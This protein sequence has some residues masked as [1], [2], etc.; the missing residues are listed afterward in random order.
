MRPLPFDLLALELDGTLLDAAGQVPP[1]LL[2]ELRAWAAGG[3]HS[4]CQFH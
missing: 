2:P 3:A 4:G 1:A